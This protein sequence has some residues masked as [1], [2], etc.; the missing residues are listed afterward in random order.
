MSIYKKLL[1]VKKKVPY[2]K[3]DKKSFQYSYATP[4][5]V[6]GVFNPLLNDVGLILKTE[7][8]EMTSERV[9]SKTKE[10]KAKFKPYKP[11]S[12]DNQGNITDTGQKEEK[13]FIDVYE[14]LYSLKL[15]FTWI[16][17]E[18][19]EKDE[20]YFYSSGINGDEKGVGSALTYA[21]RYFFLKYFN[22]P[23]DD[24][25][26]DSFQEKHLSEEQK[27]EIEENKKRLLL[28][29]TDEGKKLRSIKTVD[30]LGKEFKSMSK[31]NQSKY[32]KLVSEFKLEL[33]K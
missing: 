29:D 19:E 20:N 26:P 8:L 2:L 1:E 7:V 28:L 5:L 11:Q 18:T 13:F 9:L 27:K 22:V 21:E 17:T 33:E 24:D 6:L 10:D 3:K 25:D 4:S 23:T 30:E 12:K 32:S 16:D 14:T 15:K 31:E